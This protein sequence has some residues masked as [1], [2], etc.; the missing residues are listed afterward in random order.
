MSGGNG[1]GGDEVV[2]LV[3]RD[4]SGNDGRCTGGDRGG[5]GGENEGEDCGVAHE[6]GGGV[7]VTGLPSSSYI[8]IARHLLRYL[9][10]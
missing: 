5:S 3:M 7:E 4:D 10:S 8:T 1:G 2:S 6:G 9:F